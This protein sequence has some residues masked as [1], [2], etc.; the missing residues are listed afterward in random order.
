MSSIQRKIVLCLQFWEGDKEAAMRN[1]RRIAD[2]EPKFREDFDFCFVA[3]FDAV[4]D[5]VAVEH[6][7]KK[8]KT[9]VFTSGR[10]GQG[11]PAGPNDVWCALMQ[12][13]VSRVRD[14]E[15]AHVKA[16]FTFEADCV[17]VHR[18]WLD[19][20]NKEWTLTE[21]S[22]KWLCGWHGPHEE[23]GHINGN[24]LFHPQIAKFIP[25]LAGCAASMAWDCAFARVLSP[26]WRV[27]HFMENLYAQ[28]GNPR[29][30]LQDIVDSGV[31][32]VHGVKDLAVEQF[33]D[34]FLRK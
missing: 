6:V 19:R 1:A 31:V 8:F 33:A 18:E 21:N 10:R 13:S 22:G 11:W 28:K 14:G 25:K 16:L 7:S 26:H 9:T 24:A 2:N 32:C 17:P 12:E 3:R 29:S 15:W 34:S 5:A 20:L 30:Q 4:P 27:G 23:T